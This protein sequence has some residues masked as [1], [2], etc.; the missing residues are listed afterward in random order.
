MKKSDILL[1]LFNDSENE[2]Q[3]AHEKTEEKEEK[4]IKQGPVEI[5]QTKTKAKDEALADDNELIWKIA[6]YGL[7]GTSI[8][9]ALFLIAKHRKRVDGPSMNDMMMFMMYQSMMQNMQQQ[10]NKGTLPP[11]IVTSDDTKFSTDWS[12]W[13]DKN[14]EREY[15][16]FGSTSSDSK[17]LNQM[18]IA[19]N[20]KVRR[21]LHGKILDV[22]KTSEYIR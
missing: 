22:N 12:D 9:F 15:T 11:Q 2:V 1:D 3:V 13:W 21:N 6:K 20:W 5:K 4:E 14:K 8:A 10:Q 18:H 17:V 16:K 7:I 19:E